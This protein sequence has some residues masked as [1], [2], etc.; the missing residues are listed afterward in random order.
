M[1]SYKSLNRKHHM[2]KIGFNNSHSLILSPSHYENS[3]GVAI[4]T[5]IIPCGS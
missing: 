5:Q 2:Y 1:P 4:P 3:M